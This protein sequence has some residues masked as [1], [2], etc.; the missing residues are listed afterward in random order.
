MAVDK[1]CLLIRKAFDPT[2]KYRTRKNVKGIETVY[3][4]NHTK[5]KGVSLSIEKNAAEFE[6]LCGLKSRNI[7]LLLPLN[8]IIPILWNFMVIYFQDLEILGIVHH[9]KKWQNVQ[10]LVCF[11]SSLRVCPFDEDSAISS[12]KIEAICSGYSVNLSQN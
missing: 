3:N 2:K 10:D 9:S 7:R 6:D 1:R 8:E 11:V 4:S 12:G 5:G